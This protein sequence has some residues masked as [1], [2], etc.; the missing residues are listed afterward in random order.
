MMSSS[1]IQTE[2]KL[3]SY[4]GQQ[5]VVQHCEQN[6]NVWHMNLLISEDS[7]D[8]FDNQWATLLV[9]CGQNVIHRHDILTGEREEKVSVMALGNSL[10]IS[11]SNLEQK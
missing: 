11:T 7:E 8:R 10:K 4:F 9:R 2:F 6:G 1:K 3:K 5:R